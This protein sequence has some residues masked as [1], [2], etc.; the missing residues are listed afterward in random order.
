MWLRL[1]LRS[2]TCSRTVPFNSQSIVGKLTPNPNNTNFSFLSKAFSTTTPKLF[3]PSKASQTVIDDTTDDT[4]DDITMAKIKQP[5]AKKGKQGKKAELRRSIKKVSEDKVS[6][7]SKKQK[8]SHASFAKPKIAEKLAKKQKTLEGKEG[9]QQ[10]EEGDLKIVDDDAGAEIQFTIRELLNLPASEPSTTSNKRPAES[11]D[12]SDSNS[13]SSSS[14]SSSDSDPDSSSSSGEDTHPPAKKLKTTE[15]T[16]EATESLGFVI[17][18][19]RSTGP[20]ENFDSGLNR[21]ARRREE[22]IARQKLNFQKQWKVPEGSTEPH[23]GVDNELAE[24]I[25]KYDRTQARVEWK[26]D[27]SKRMRAAKG[28]KELEKRKEAIAEL[29]KEKRNPPTHLWAPK[30]KRTPEEK[31]RRAQLKK[32]KKPKK[33][34]AKIKNKA[35][36]SQGS[37]S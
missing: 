29:A 27:W 3:H 16:Q 36:Y 8:P 7:A 25:D 10:D 37:R 11:D 26:M 32:A 9:K 1:L 35:K 2:V 14:S 18:T 6:K 33:D 28:I 20:T 34:K 31:R 19:E 30:V 4:T 17:D 15:P 5:H 13:S 21:K 24:W 23:E 12:D 22:L